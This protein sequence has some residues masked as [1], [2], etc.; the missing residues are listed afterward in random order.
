MIDQCEESHILGRV[1]QLC[2]NGVDSVL[3]IGEGYLGNRALDVLCL[4]HRAWFR[5]DR[6]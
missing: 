1:N 5:G 6:E 2:R 3:E 4:R